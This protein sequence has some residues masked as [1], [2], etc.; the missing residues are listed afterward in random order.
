MAEKS[1]ISWTDSR[2]PKAEPEVKVVY[3]NVYSGGIGG[4][5]KTLNYALKYKL[6]GES[7]RHTV[8]ISTTSEIMEVK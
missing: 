1:N 6:E 5:H 8:K 2:M 3:R 7:Y 4:E